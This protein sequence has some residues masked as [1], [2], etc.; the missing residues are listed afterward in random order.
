MYHR[1]IN[2]QR[3]ENP[4][5]DVPIKVNS[6]FDRRVSKLIAY[7]GERL[8]VFDLNRRERMAQ[9]VEVLDKTDKFKNK[10]KL[11]SSEKR[12]HAIHRT[13]RQIR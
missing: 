6:H 12:A 4:R 13:P 8:V 7:V 2:R 1:P 5:L 3:F 11:V 9:V 10:I